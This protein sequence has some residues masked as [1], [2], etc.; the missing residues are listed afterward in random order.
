MNLYTRTHPSV[1]VSLPQ[2]TDATPLID[3]IIVAVAHKCEPFTNHTFLLAAEKCT[4]S[5]SSTDLFFSSSPFSLL[6]DSFCQLSFETTSL[7]KVK[8]FKLRIYWLQHH[9]NGWD[10]IP[11]V[12]CTKANV[13]LANTQCDLLTQISRWMCTSLTWIKYNHIMHRCDLW[14][15]QKDAKLIFHYMEDNLS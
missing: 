12:L 2:C 11:G 1:C 13:P 4:Y 7:Y 6:Y 9:L 15:C 8:H 5:N 14:H 3:V 10:Q